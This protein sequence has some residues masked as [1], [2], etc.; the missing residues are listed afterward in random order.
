MSGWNEPTV[1]VSPQLSSYSVYSSGSDGLR[2][3]CL[4]SLVLDTAD[5]VKT[6][7][8]MTKIESQI[9]VPQSRLKSR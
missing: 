9:D 2:L 5:I 4:T 7:H 3:Y 1:Q 6:K 8:F